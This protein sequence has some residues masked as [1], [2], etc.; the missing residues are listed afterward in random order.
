MYTILN[1]MSFTGVFIGTDINITIN[2]TKPKTKSIKK[3]R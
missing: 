2:V 3:E 1:S